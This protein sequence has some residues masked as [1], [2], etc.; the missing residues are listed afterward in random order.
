[1]QMGNFYCSGSEETY[2]Y[3]NFQTNDA[4]MD[5]SDFCLHLNG[6]DFVIDSTMN[7]TFRYDLITGAGSFAHNTFIFGGTVHRQNGD[8]YPIRLSGSKWQ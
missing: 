7:I 3:I 6:Y 5:P 2:K 1:M 4:P 8:E